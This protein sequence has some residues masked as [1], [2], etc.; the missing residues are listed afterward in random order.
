MD[1]IDWLESYFNTKQI[2]EEVLEMPESI[3]NSQMLANLFEFYLE[4]STEWLKTQ[5]NSSLELI[6]A[7]SFDTIFKFAQTFVINLEYVQDPTL[8]IFGNDKIYTRKLVLE[9]N[10]RL[11]Y[12]LCVR[13]KSAMVECFQINFSYLINN[14][15]EAIEELVKITWIFNQLEPFRLRK[16]VQEPIIDLIQSEMEAMVISKCQNDFEEPMVQFHLD[17]LETRLAGL[18]SAV[19]GL[20][21]SL[22]FSWYYKLKFHVYRTIGLLLY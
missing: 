1:A 13:L 21:S 2:G 11:Y 6:D 5:T 10:S 17:F 18:I 7:A 8:K 4:Y 16:I 12:Q 9:I 22:A 14:D 19:F 20:G 15:Q 3:E